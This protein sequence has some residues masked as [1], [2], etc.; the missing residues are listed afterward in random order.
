MKSSIIYSIYNGGNQNQYT[1][2]YI[3]YIM[4]GIKNSI[5]CI[6]PNTHLSLLA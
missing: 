1:Y 3:V 4:G 5:H 2:K 6:Y